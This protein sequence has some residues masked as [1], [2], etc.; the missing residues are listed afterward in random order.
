MKKTSIKHKI[1][2]IVLGMSIVSLTVFCAAA[3]GGLFSIRAQMQQS[4]A[5]LGDFATRNSSLFLE[6][7]A[8]D[9]LMAQARDQSQIINE[10]LLNIANRAVYLSDYTTQ[11]Y[12]NARKFKPSPIP[13]SSSANN[14]VLTMQLQSANG[15]ADY[16]QIKEEAELLGNVTAAYESNR[17]D[18]D[19]IAAI[20]L[21]TESGFS[22]LFD[23]FSDDENQVFDPRRRP[24]YIGSKEVS[25]TFWTS[26]YI[27]AASGN[28][29]ITCSH[30]FNGADGVFTGVTG[31]DVIIED[32]NNEIVNIQAGEN[33]Y[34]F[35]IDTDGI[36]ISAREL[37]KSEDGSY[38]KRS[39]FRE[40]SPEYNSV[41]K[42]MVAGKVGVEKV[43]YENGEIFIAYS[44]IPTTNWSLA[45]ALPVT[46][47]MGLVTENRTAIERMT[48]ET[49]GYVNST[50]MVMLIVFV[51][52]FTV[53]VLVIVYLGGKLS[54]KITRPIITLKESHERIAGGELDTR[55]E[56]KTGDEIEDLGASVNRMAVN[57][58]EYIVNLQS[59][60][61]EK[62]RIG[63]ELDVATKIQ[64]SMLPCIFPAFPHRKEFDIYASMLPAKEVGGDFYDFFLIDDNTL[65]VVMADVSGKGVPAA[66]FMVITKTLI[67]NNAQYGKS[68]KEVFE[69]VNNMLCENNEAGMFVTAFMGY[70]DITCGKFTYVNAG[71]NPP[72]IRTGGGKYEF[73]KA[74]PG[75]VLAGMEDMFYKQGEV[76]L[77]KG[78]EL[79]LYTDGV[80]EAMNNEYELFS[81]PRLVEV[82]NNYTDLPLKEFSVSIKREID[83]FAQGAE[84]ADDITMLALRYLGGLS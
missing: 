57:L 4:S 7:E 73:L 79:F 83:K 41:I 16:P 34:A 13:F 64:A 27:D 48:E 51:V 59:V 18:M 30:P 50:I 61:A 20:Y 81:D 45:I 6:R 72:L 3:F 36:L 76:T 44:Q 55:V 38:E 84:Q 31:I 78:D 47:I 11:I 52:V 26:P 19:V 69:T 23:P 75:L 21:G 33:G 1:L 15:K 65:A 39:A 80:T 71:H 74:K 35:V 60:T 82:A 56:L 68:P 5:Q 8:V 14:G 63:A 40:N 25:G 32:L 22:I 77:H 54:D 67:K 58:R 37:M 2:F 12:K 49:L 62:E 28:L 17:K 66:L 43:S 70:L 9:K 46:E 10:R 24:W 29:M 42:S 53:A